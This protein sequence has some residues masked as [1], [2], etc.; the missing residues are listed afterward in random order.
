MLN[1]YSWKMYRFNLCLLDLIYNLVLITLLYYSNTNYLDVVTFNLE[2]LIIL[3]LYGIFHDCCLGLYLPNLPFD[4]DTLLHSILGTILGVIISVPYCIRY[5]G[6]LFP[7]KRYYEKHRIAFYLLFV[8]LFLQVVLP[9]SIFYKIFFVKDPSKIRILI[10]VEYILYLL[11][12]YIFIRD[13]FLPSTIY[14]TTK[15]KN[16]W[17]HL[18]VEE[19]RQKFIYSLIFYKL[20]VQNAFSIFYFFK[21][22]EHIEPNLT[23]H[24]PCLLRSCLN[25]IPTKHVDTLNTPMYLYR[26][27][28]FQ[29]PAK[30]N[31]KV[32]PLTRYI[33][34]IITGDELK[35]KDYLS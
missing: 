2:I 10:M 3:R 30:I 14:C 29:I 25:F 19:D 16:I 15:Y 12:S 8:P 18:V 17:M 35:E 23:P 24:T 4:I 1:D 13:I 6:Y 11:L 22:G 7:S 9:L 31:R 26:D 27:S 33:Y 20:C 34:H 5:I 21:F 32:V 28:Y